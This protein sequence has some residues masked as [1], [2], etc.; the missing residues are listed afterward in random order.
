M[1][2]KRVSTAKI[3]EE[4]SQIIVYYLAALVKRLGGE[5][6]IPVTELLQLN[7]RDDFLVYEVGAF[8][9]VKIT[10]GRNG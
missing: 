8:G 2:Q 10:H 9:D 1:A 4:H 6:E 3:G 7:Y 5:V